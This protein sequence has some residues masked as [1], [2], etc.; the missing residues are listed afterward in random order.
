MSHGGKGD[1]PRPFSVDHNTY[2]NNWENI[3]G[4]KSK[5]PDEPSSKENTESNTLPDSG[6]KTDSLN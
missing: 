1:T 6:Q 4:K 5:L 2:S 3:F